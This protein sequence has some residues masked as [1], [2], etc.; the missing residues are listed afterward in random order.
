MDQVPLYV[1][2]WRVYVVRRG[3]L[4][5]IER[6]LSVSFGDFGSSSCQIGSLT[7]PGPGIQV[8][9]LRLLAYDCLAGKRSPSSLI[10]PDTNLGEVCEDVRQERLDMH[11]FK[12]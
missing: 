12:E 4:F 7:M 1:K 5:D 6:P 11:A 8:S 9:E 10:N 3:I 2:C